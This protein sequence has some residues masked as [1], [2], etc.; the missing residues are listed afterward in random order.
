MHSVLHSLCWRLLLF[1][2]P[3]EIYADSGARNALLFRLLRQ[4]TNFRRAD[5]ITNVA[6]GLN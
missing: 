4:R 1:E 3:R 5:G 2:A 6:D